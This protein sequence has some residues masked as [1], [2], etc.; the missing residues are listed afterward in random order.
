MMHH[1]RFV[2]QSA[3]ASVFSFAALGKLG[4]RDAVS[5]LLASLPAFGVPARL[6]TRWFAALL[7]A[8]ELGA[9]AALVI[10]P[11]LGGVLAAGLL[12]GFA[13]GIIHVLRSGAAVRCRCFGAGGV[14]VGRANVI[15]NIA[16]AALAIAVAIGAP[17]R[18]FLVQPDTI[19]AALA[20]LGAGA[21]IARWDDLVFLFSTASLGGSR[22][23]SP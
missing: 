4:N 14:P 10:A 3:L 9:A 20:G 6:A 17:A 21:L 16:L 15:R 5:S 23:S 1:L 22:R 12:A 11:R 13:L 18:P 2:C 7:V 8:A 19:L